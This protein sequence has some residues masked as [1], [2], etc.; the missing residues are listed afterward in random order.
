MFVELL[1]CYI[2]SVL[3]RLA[4]KQLT[5]SFPAAESFRPAVY[6]RLRHC[7]RFPALASFSEH[8]LQTI[9]RD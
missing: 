9:P 3:Y 7:R 1:D 5:Y 2:E 6:G 4:L 8:C